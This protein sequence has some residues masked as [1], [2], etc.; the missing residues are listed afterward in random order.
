MKVVFH[1]GFMV[2]Y[3]FIVGGVIS[4]IGKGITGSSIGML[5]KSRGYDV[6]MQKFDPYLNVDP[7]TM[8]PIQHGEVYV[9]EDGFETDLDLGHYERFTDTTFDRRSSVTMGQ[10]YSSV[11]A[12]E[13]HGDFQGHTV[14]VIPHITNEIK[15]RFYHEDKPN[16][17]KITFCLI[18]IGGTIGDIESQPFFEAIRQFKHEI[19]YQNAIIVCTT[20]VPYL[21][22]SGELKTKP[23]QQ[24]IR[25]LQSAGLRADI[26]SCRCEL[27]LGQDIKDKISLFCDVPTNHV[28]DN[29]DVSTVYEV[30][31]VLEKQGMATA[32]L[33]SLGLHETNANHAKWDQLVKNIITPMHQV[34]IAMVGKYMDLHDS[35]LS[36]VEALRHAGATLNT[37]VDIKWV[38]SESCETGDLAQIFAGID[39]IL[40]P[41]GFG[42]RGTEGMIN[43]VK[44]ARE[45]KIPFL[46]LCLGMQIAT[47]EFARDVLN[48]KDANSTE[49]DPK[50]T[51]PVIYLMPDQRGV[52]DM[53]ATMRLGAYPCRLEKGSLAQRLY[54]SDEIS[55]R[56][57]HRYEFNNAYREE[58]EKHGMIISGVYPTKNI[59]E[60]IELKDHPFFI[61][62]QAHPEFKSTLLNPHPLFL[63]FVKASHDHKILRKIEAKKAAGIP[64]FEE[65]AVM[66]AKAKKVIG[67]SVKN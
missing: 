31:L 35:Y 47:I 15:S 30:P 41:G 21:R 66:K 40:L 55:E 49:L 62:T 56:H 39:G 13:R 8:N 53:G 50:T 29:T 65:E 9:T 38:E 17:D 24:A 67:P 23:T 20:L 57:R 64:T 63:G 22:T 33:E 43:T 12:K 61:A 59:V 25:T 16:P 10:I 46:G 42:K 14:Q 52:V 19:G 36:V 11:L 7:G 6:F 54:G 60:I 27:A 3:I 18:E 4:G 32:I 1:G 45:H 26:I 34:S 51:H 2:K 37:K 5:L 44:Y 58:Y 48:Y 28:F